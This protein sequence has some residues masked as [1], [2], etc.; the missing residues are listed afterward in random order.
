MHFRKCLLH[1]FIKNAYMFGRMFHEIRTLYDC[2]KKTIAFWWANSISTLLTLNTSDPLS[3]L[4]KILK[5]GCEWTWEG[6]QRIIKYLKRA[7]ATYL[8]VSFFTGY[9]TTL[10]QKKA[11]TLASVFLRNGRCSVDRNRIFTVPLLVHWLVIY[12]RKGGSLLLVVSQTHNS[13]VS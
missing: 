3:F 9:T 11:S 2:I 4:L 7:E 1:T 8:G 6:K 5:E 12:V 10:F 13:K